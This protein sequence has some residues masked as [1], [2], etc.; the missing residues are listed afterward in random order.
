MLTSLLAWRRSGYGFFARFKRREDGAAA[1]EFAL[2]ALPFFGLMFAIIELA[3]FFFASRYLEDGLYNASRKI[4]TQRLTPGTICS[5]FKTEVE[6]ELST[7]LSPSKLTLS[8]TPL[9]SFSG[10]GTALD[11]ASAGCTFGGTGQTVII[12]ASYAYPFQGFRFI[13]GSA[14]IGKDITLSASTALRVE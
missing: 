12:K 14:S 5:S 8:V 2:V 4:L 11:L 6:N 7:L 10:T 1:V 9:S 13:A 3:I